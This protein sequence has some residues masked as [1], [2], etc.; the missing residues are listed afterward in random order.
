MANQ[1]LD[2]LTQIPN[3]T[4]AT[5]LIYVVRGNVDYRADIA[6]VVVTPTA[7]ATSHEN[8]GADEISVA[9]LSGE[10]ADPQPPKNH[11]H[12][13]NK[14]A[15]ANTHESADT[16]TAPTSLHHTL[17]TGANQA[18]AGNHTH[19]GFEPV[20][21]AASQAEME[22]G[23]ETAIRSMTPQRVAQAIAALA[24]AGSGT[25]TYAVFS[26]LSNQPPAA[27]YATFD[28]RN[29]IAV[30]DFDDST[31]E[32]AVFVGVIPEAASL[33]SGLKVRLHWMATSATS[34]NVRWGVQFERMNTDE[35]ADSFDTATE[36]HTATNGTSGIV[37]VTEITATTI[38]GV[39][40]GDAFRLK[41]YRDVSDTTNDTMTG[42]AEL[43]AVEIRSAA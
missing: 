21:T 28:T 25:K 4:V 8:G 15:Q 38:D 37:T 13:A 20:Q 34:G 6:N 43:V 41:V 32:A 30:L 3:A 31:E 24:A 12:S 39:T 11:D 27:N 33:G 1:S 19:T 42:D 26:A 23:T 36:A 5:D 16:D 18:A 40:A 14:L 7:H 2:L 22:A 10:L 9:G 17:G 29:S 35:D